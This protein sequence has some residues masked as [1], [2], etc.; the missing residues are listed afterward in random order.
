MK[1]KLI[2]E[3]LNDKM[4]INAFITWLMNVVNIHNVRMKELRFILSVLMN[5]EES[6]N[7]E[8]LSYLNHEISELSKGTIDHKEFIEELIDK[9][10]YFL[11][12]KYAQELKNF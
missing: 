11:D 3:S 8:L 7:E 6:T 4:S 1:A 10:D 12:F 2:R 9:R 5:D